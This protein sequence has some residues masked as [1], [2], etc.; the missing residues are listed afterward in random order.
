MT[1]HTGH[2]GRR[3]QVLEAVQRAAEPVGVSEIAAQLGIHPNTARFHLDGLVGAG[4][5][6]RFPGTPSGP[7]RPRVVYRPRPGLARGGLRRYQELADILLSRIAATSEHP[8][9]EATDIGRE[10]GAALVARPVP[11]RRVGPAEAAIRLVRM[12]A[13]LDFAPD[14]A[15][16][17]PGVPERV[18]L[19]H[20]PFRELAE[21]HRDLVCP[22]HLGL[23][24]GA[25]TA[26]RAPLAVTALQPFTDDT[27]CVAQLAPAGRPQP[28]VVSPPSGASTSPV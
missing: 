18:R 25:L 22:L 16:G 8:T 27:T 12:L 14:E 1:G 24:Q 19:R 28:G 20:C 5:V 15:T 11:A 3:R 7:G 23:M 2:A 9:A 26:L 13:D 6:E 17:G 10:W 21:Q 4:I